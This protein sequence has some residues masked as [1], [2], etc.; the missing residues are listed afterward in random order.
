M[1]EQHGGYRAPSKPA[2]VSGPG[3]LSQ[4]TD[5]PEARVSGLGYGENGPLNAAASSLP[6]GS[7]APARPAPAIVPLGAPSQRPSEPITAG[8]PF[9]PGPGPGAGGARGPLSLTQTL[10]RLMGNDIAGDIETLYLRAE[11]NLM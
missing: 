5:T 4:R 7:S 11:A 10:E 2:P 9:G 3:A 8:A 6:D 1:P